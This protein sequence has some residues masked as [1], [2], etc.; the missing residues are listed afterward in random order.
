MFELKGLVRIALRTVAV[1]I[2]PLKPKEIFMDHTLKAGESLAI[3]AGGTY[4]YIELP[5]STQARGGGCGGV[6][7]C[8]CT[9]LSDRNLRAAVCKRVHFF[10]VVASLAIH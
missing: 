3:V 7:V 5:T 8:T 9:P 10:K 2:R 1:V 4:A 6:G